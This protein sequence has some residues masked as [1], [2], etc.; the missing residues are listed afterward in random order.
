MPRPTRDSY[1]TVVAGAGPAGILSALHAA[2]RGPVLLAE[3]GPLPRSKSCGGMLHQLSLDTLHEY[4]SVPESIIVD[5]RTVNFRYNDW[6][7]EITK[8]TDLAFLNVDRAGFDEWLLSLLPDNVEIVARTRVSG[9][10]ERDG[11]LLITLGIEDGTCGVTAD[12]LIGADGA[13][14]SIRRGL[15]MR[16]SASYVTLQ[17]F[18]QRNG[19]VDPVFDCIYMR[20]VG[21]FGYSYIIPKG[22]VA[23]IGSVFYPKTRRPWERQDAIIASMR[24]RLPQLGASLRRE[25]SAALCVRSAEDILPGAGRVLLAGEAGGFMS[26]TSGEGIS[27]ALR[28]GRL[29]GIAAAGEPATALDRYVDLAETIRQDIVRRLRWLPFME[30]R[31]GKYLAG[32]VPTPLVSRVTQGL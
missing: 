5:P 16:Q 19:D 10:E 9:F 23:L 6:D 20:G 4:G 2:E 11:G 29:A 17:D 7:R 32:F 3:S 18:V 26:P 27:Y 31:A 15:G 13:R 1:A 14:S 8:E 21:E 30:S 24:E 12:L 25:A 28:T 22:D